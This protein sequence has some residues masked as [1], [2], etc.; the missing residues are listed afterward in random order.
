MT[1]ELELH[2]KRRKVAT[3]SG[4]TVQS[5]DRSGVRNASVTI[6]CARSPAAA[7]TFPGLEAVPAIDGTVP[8]RLKWHGR[9]LSAAGANDSGARRVGSLVGLPARLLIFLCLPT[10][11]APF[12]RRIAALPEERLIVG[13]K[14]EFLSAVA[15]R[16][17]QI[18]RHGEPL[19]R[20]STVSLIPPF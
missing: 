16:Q 18:I 17:L 12:W 13:R 4:L 19:L 7:C 11:F 8:S 15:A 10:C 5:V 14:R 20:A 6:A 9:L 1:T 3:L 2:Q